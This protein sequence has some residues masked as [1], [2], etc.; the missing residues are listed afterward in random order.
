M[1]LLKD[2]AKTQKLT[3]DLIRVIVFSLHFRIYILSRMLHDVTTVAALGGGTRRELQKLSRSKEE[4][5]CSMPTCH[6]SAFLAVFLGAFI[7][8]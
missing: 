1:Y 6:F 2:R 5:S 3:S 4:T 7:E 8:Q